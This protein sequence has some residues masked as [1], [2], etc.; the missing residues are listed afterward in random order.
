MATVRYAARLAED[1]ARIAEHLGAHQ[2]SGIGERIDEVIEAMQVL[3]RH[4]LIGR[5]AEPGR[6]ELVIGRGSH[7]YVALYRY[8]ELDDL[9]EVLAL[10]GQKEAGFEDG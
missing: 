3:A 4:P 7:G 10:R 1:L 9:V 6:R 2:V 5:K 8:D